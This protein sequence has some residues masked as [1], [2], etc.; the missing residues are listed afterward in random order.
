MGRRGDPSL[1]AAAQRADD[2]ATRPAPEELP[3]GELPT[4]TELR[5]KL[6]ACAAVRSAVDKRV[7]QLLAEE[8]GRRDREDARDAEVET[9]VNQL[10]DGDRADKQLVPSS[11]DSSSGRRS[12]GP[13]RRRHGEDPGRRVT[14]LL[15]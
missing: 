4:A 1:V 13:V 8:D 10:L 6:A 7:A 9:E 2:E 5:E 3:P 11:S 14:C 12:P 15:G